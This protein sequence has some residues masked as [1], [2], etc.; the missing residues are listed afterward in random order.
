MFVT[1]DG[2]VMFFKK[3]VKFL[4]KEI[5]RRAQ[6]GFKCEGTERKIKVVIKKIV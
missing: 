5:F 3:N 2:E 1:V 6:I 4:Q